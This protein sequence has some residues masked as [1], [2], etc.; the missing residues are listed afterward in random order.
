[1]FSSLMNIQKENIFRKT[2]D[3]DQHLR[4]V[5]SIAIICENALK[6]AYCKLDKAYVLDHYDALVLRKKK[7]LRTIFSDDFFQFFDDF[8]TSLESA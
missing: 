2:F 1:M 3:L 5:Q 8:Q 7:V 6:S 4:G